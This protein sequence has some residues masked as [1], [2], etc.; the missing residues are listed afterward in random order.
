MTTVTSA[1][2]AQDVKQ[3]IHT[4]ESRKTSLRGEYITL[5]NQAEMESLLPL[6]SPSGTSVVKASVQ[7]LT[8][9]KSVRL[10]ANF[11]RP[12]HGAYGH[13]VHRSVDLEHSEL[14]S[15]RIAAS[16][17]S[18]I[19]GSLWGWKRSWHPFGVRDGYTKRYFVSTNSN[20]E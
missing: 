1:S 13:L 3:L 16:L 18:K 9:K 7:S 6:R 14:G 17:A 2:N 10:T 4:S 8:S 5:I 11:M 19:F 12:V 15:Q 20:Q